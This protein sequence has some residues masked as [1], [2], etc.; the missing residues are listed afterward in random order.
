MSTGVKELEDLL[1]VER[2]HTS[3]FE[4]WERRATHPLA[5]T[6]FRLTADKEA[7]HIR[8]V[9]LLIEIAKADSRGEDLGVTEEELRFWIDDEAK[10]G[11]IYEKRAESADEP[12]V[13][14]ALEQMGHDETTNAEM[15]RSLLEQVSS[16]R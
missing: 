15:L 14:A 4:E 3:N 9:E 12:W 8:W 5:K 10:E 7:N 1:Y 6:I 2:G 16:K 11:D 13:R